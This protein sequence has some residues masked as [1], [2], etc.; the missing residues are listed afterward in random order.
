MI[1]RAPGIL[2]FADTG[3][4]EVRGGIVM[5]GTL[6]V[7][8]GSRVY[9][10]TSAGVLTQI[11]GA[12]ITGNGPVRMATNGTV[13]VVCPGNGDGF[14]CDGVS[15]DPITDATFTGGGGCDPVFL[16]G[17]LVFRRPGT[18]RFFNSG[19]NVL[20]FN[21]LDV[22]TAE[23]APDNLVA[24]TVN[25]RELILAGET[26]V[27]R[28]YDAAASPGSPFARSPDGFHEIGCAA[29]W[30]VA[31][32]DNTVFMLASDR[33]VRRLSSSWQR[34]SHHAIESIIHRMARVD[35]CQAL[36]YRQEGHH[37]IAFTFRNAGRTLVLDVNTGEWHERDSLINTVPLGRWRPSAIVDAY[38]KQIVGDSQSGKLGILD[39]DTHEEWGEPQRVSATFQ[40]VYA[41]RRLVIHK[42]F[43]LAITA[44]QG[45]TLG[46]GS[47]PL[48]TLHISDDGGNTFRARPVR[49]LG[50][51]GEYRRRV[52]WWGLGSSRERVYRLEFSDPVSMML[53]DAQ[54]DAEGA[55][56]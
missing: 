35:D 34:V 50:K 10:V 11:T 36:A 42:R 51:M 38:G 26:S 21:A 15:V 7:V 2:P 3:Q 13:F 28:W 33:T 24:L 29:A 23:G 46:Q 54:L 32:Q 41:E 55:R 47:N 53:L 39:P 17:Y 12:T 44:G 9:S 25:H 8:A 49:E 45:T 5:G 56:L 27:E 22:A 19:L 30:S 6:Y 1:V 40:P 18:A 16:D 31:N 37:F 48:C 14:S 43:E 20:T 52:S 4:P